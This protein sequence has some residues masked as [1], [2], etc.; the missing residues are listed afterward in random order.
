MA[1]GERTVQDGSLPAGQLWAGRWE[2]MRSSCSH[3]P[4]PLLLTSP[5]KAHDN[6]GGASLS[7]MHCCLPACSVPA[8]TKTIR[9]CS[10]PGTAGRG[11]A[12]PVLIRRANYS[13][14]EHCCGHQLTRVPQLPGSSAGP[15][16]P[17]AAA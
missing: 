12:D 7:G 10:S 9:G 6:C 8:G 17:G 15:S 4:F 14:R 3:T 11:E 16:L 5:G 1:A 2:V 13:G